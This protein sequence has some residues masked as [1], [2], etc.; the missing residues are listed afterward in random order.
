M[1]RW[2]R[3]DSDGSDLTAEDFVYSWK[4]AADPKTAADYAYMFDVIAGYDEFQAGDAEALQVSA[5]DA[6]TIVVTLKSPCA[7][8][9]DLVAFPTYFPV[10]QSVVEAKASRPTSL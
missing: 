9:L 3:P 5:P 8:M 4:R 10:K 7:Y 2:F 6:K 1:V